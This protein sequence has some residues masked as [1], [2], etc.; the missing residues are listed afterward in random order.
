MTTI[1]TRVYAA[2]NKARAAVTALKAELS[3]DRITLDKDGS[4]FVVTVRAQFG[5]AVPAIELLDAQGPIGGSEKTEVV[6]G[7]AHG[8]FSSFFD[9]PELMNLKS[10][11]VLLNEAAPF[12]KFWN[13]PLLVDLKSKTEL[14]NQAAPLSTALSI[15]TISD[16]KPFSKL[17]DDK[18]SV[19]LVR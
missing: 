13:Q 9:F 4:K 6:K 14:L 11:T 12:S 8:P 2:E 16:S 18:S 10:T 15:P 7:R 17:L 5:Q 1:I 19:V 3:D